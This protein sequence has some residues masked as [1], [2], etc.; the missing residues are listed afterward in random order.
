MVRHCSFWHC[1]LYRSS[2]IWSW[3]PPSSFVIRS[4]ESSWPSLR[5][6]PNKHSKMWTLTLAL[7]I[8]TPLHPG[9]DDSDRFLICL[10]EFI[11]LFDKNHPF[12]LHTKFILFYLNKECSL[13]SFFFK[14]ECEEIFFTFETVINFEFLEEWYWES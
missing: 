4:S 9:G 2:W 7:D 3:A 10:S 11:K 6:T 1:L 8:D 13:F 12:I 14:E 5:S